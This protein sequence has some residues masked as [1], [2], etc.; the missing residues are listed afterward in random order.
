VIRAYAKYSDALE[1]G[2]TKTILKPED[3]LRRCLVKII[4]KTRILRTRDFA[5]TVPLVNVERAMLAKR[6]DS[7][8]RVS[9]NRDII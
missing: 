1:K 2:T 3:N 5:S 7:W 9:E 8:G 6:A 4:T